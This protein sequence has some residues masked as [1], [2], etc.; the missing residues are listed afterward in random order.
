MSQAFHSLWLS[1]AC[2]HFE[3]PLCIIGRR[4][5]CGIVH[6]GTHGANSP[7]WHGIPDRTPPHKAIGGPV[8]LKNLAVGHGGATNATTAMHGTVLWHSYV[9]DRLCVALQQLMGQ[10]QH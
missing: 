10:P 7:L 6:C 8:V 3:E 1:L 9:T 5:W 2:T 4:P